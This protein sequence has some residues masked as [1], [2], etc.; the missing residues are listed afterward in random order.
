METGAKRKL[1]RSPAAGTPCKWS[2]MERS[3]GERKDVDAVSLACVS[4]ANGGDS[5]YDYRSLD[6][7]N[8]LLLK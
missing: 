7:H 8:R 3:G 6:G 4:S 2:N 1:N 5:P